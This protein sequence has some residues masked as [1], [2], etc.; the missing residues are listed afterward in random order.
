[1]VN[2]SMIRNAVSLVSCARNTVQGRLPTDHGALLRAP[3]SCALRD[4][5]GIGWKGTRDRRVAP[6]ICGMECGMA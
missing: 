3:G 1:M 6:K 5:I 2:W 4:F